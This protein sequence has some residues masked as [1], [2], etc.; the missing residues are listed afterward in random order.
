MHATSDLFRLNTIASTSSSAA[1]AASA[2][3]QQQKH[4]TT[5]VLWSYG[6]TI[7][8]IAISYNIID[9][10]SHIPASSSAE[11]QQ[12]HE[13]RLGDHQGDAYS[14]YPT[15][16]LTSATTAMNTW[17]NDVIGGVPLH[18]SESQK[19]PTADWPWWV[20]DLQPCH[21]ATGEQERTTSSLPER[22]MVENKLCGRP[23]Q[24]APP[25]CKLTFDQCRRYYT[26]K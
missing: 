24:Y 15:T 23:P 22:K 4:Q 9:I 13:C 6:L 2:G 1:L 3:A 20:V 17:P 11:Q 25:P 18:L 19:Q 7:K 21:A 14:A 8:L 5:T 10:I 16:T 12:Q 26:V